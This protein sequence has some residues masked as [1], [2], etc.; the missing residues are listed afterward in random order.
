MRRRK[1]VMYHQ[2]PPVSSRGL[3]SHR[4]HIRRRVGSCLRNGSRCVLSSASGAFSVSSVR[5]CEGASRRVGLEGTPRGGWRDP[6]GSQAPS[7]AQAC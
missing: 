4:A 5:L 3:Y 2:E 6:G 1:P 7:L